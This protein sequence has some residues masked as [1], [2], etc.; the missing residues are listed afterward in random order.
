MQGPR[1]KPGSAS[2]EVNKKVHTFVVGNNKSDEITSTLK[3]LGLHMKDEGHMPNLDLILRPTS[4]VGK[5]EALCEHAEKLAI[6]FGLLNTPQGETLR[7]TKN[8]R[9]CNDCHS[10][11]K[12][13][14]RVEKREIIL[15]DECCVHH[16]KDGLCSC[17]DLF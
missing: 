4:D 10:A 16:F 15:R 9:M 12:M 3:T 8:L 6:A 1:K 5:E 17:G 11:S 7:V 13:I 14:S 2:I